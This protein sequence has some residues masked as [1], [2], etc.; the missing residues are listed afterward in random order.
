MKT[1]VS[2][3]LLSTGLALPL[4]AG[5][6][7]GLV[8]Y[9]PFDGNSNDSSTNGNN[10][11][12]HNAV[13]AADRF[14]VGDHAYQF[15]GTDAYISAPNRSYLS[16]PNGQFT[17]SLWATV[18]AFTPDPMFLAGLDNGPGE[19]VKWLIPFGWM[20]NQLP[21]PSPGD[22]LNFCLNDGGHAYSLS[23]TRYRPASGSWHQYTFTKAGTNYAIYI[24]GI[25]A[26]GTNYMVDASEGYVLYSN[27]VGPS[28]IPSGITA[29]LTI[30]WAEGPGYFHGKLDDVR[31]YNRAFSAD[32]VSQLH[33]FEAPPELNIRK[34]VYLDA[35]HLWVGTN[36]QLQASTDL[37]AWT[38]VGATFT[39]TNSNWRSPGYW[40]V[41]NWNRLFFR[42]QVAP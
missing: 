28:V 26:S 24:D 2:S 22:Y 38:N 6:N 4:S 15:N 40:D 30:G 9:Y 25:P 11:T 10:G 37:V 1:L 35:A 18:D 8:A 42:L 41:D 7:D 39:A 5:I 36:Y 27:V 21:N 19:Q 33:D 12:P 17:I 13:L 16:F 3:I 34:A 14:G 29:P 20:P 32:E 23:T 31:I